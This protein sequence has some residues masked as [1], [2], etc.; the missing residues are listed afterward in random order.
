M[1][2]ANK[3]TLSPFDFLKSINDTKKNIMELP[4]HEKMYVP[5]VTN[6]S[7]SYFPDTVLLANEMNRYHHID[8][9]LQYQFLIN[10]VRK[11]KRFSKWVKP[12]IENDIESVKE[13]Y[14]YSNDKARQVLRLLSS[15]QLT[16]I[17]DKVNKGGRK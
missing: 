14:G 16:I 3:K 8:S 2:G 7:L 12:E 4:E 17:R 11:R 5:F 10:I 9:K 1:V 6:R 15:E 13:Y